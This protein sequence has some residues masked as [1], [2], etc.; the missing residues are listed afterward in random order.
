MSLT[1]LFYATASVL[2]LICLVIGCPVSS[3]AVEISSMPESLTVDWTTFDLTAGSSVPSDNEGTGTVVMSLLEQVADNLPAD[4][5]GV[6]I[7]F[8]GP[9]PGYEHYALAAPGVISCDFNVLFSNLIAKSAI[10]SRADVKKLRFNYTNQKCSPQIQKGDP[11][12]LRFF[13]P[14]SQTVTQQYGGHGVATDV[15]A[16]L[17]SLQA[18]VPAN[19]NV[20]RVWFRKPIPAVPS[21]LKQ[22]S[23]FTSCDTNQIFANWIASTSGLH[24]LAGLSYDYSPGGSCDLQYKRPLTVVNS[25]LFSYG[26]PFISRG[27][28]LIGLREV[29]G[30]SDHFSTD[31]LQTAQSK[32]NAN[33]IRFQISQDG[34]DPQSPNYSQDFVGLVQK[35]VTLA[36]Q[37]GF[38]VIASVQHE[39]DPDY[40]K[41]TNMPTSSTLNAV[42]TLSRLFGQDAG[43]M[44]ETFNEPS[45]I[46]NFVNWHLWQNGGTD[47]SGNVYVG[48]N[49]LIEAARNAGA[50]N[51]FIADGLDWAHSFAGAP[52][53]VDPLNE[54]IYGVHPYFGRYDNPNLWQQNFE[55]WTQQGNVVLA[56]E[57]SAPTHQGWCEPGSGDALPES[58]NPGTP[59]LFLNYLA[60]NQIGLVGWAFDVPGTIVSDYNGTPNSYVHESCSVIGDGPGEMLQQ[61]YNQAKIK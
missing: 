46:P 52:L 10:R 4:L 34:L 8:S 26:H 19:A 1:S 36:R 17:T 49:Q 43:V 20:T 21:Y 40:N 56:S 54:L 39:A 12:I 25:N 57:W 33:L 15:E 35:R 61:Y 59:G 30:T 42:I 51:V 13:V 23:S 45:F 41:N 27:V 22:V 44:I 31:L 5:T 11:V 50:Q 14:G 29:K 32:W 6:Q 2:G 38:F 60:A 53:L 48:Q 16:L 28:Q 9:T 3:S 37:M 24:S 47:G 58:N 7:Q 18:A 55:S